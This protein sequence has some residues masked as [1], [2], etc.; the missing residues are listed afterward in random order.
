M[1]GRGFDDTL[2][3]RRPTIQTGQTQMRTGFIDEFQALDRVC[4][5]LAHKL[6]AQAFHA[7]RVALAVVER[8][9]FSAKFNAG[10]SRHIMLGCAVTCWVFASRS[11]NSAK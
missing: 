4:G 1:T 8:L 9:F 10:N 6:P 11:H 5:Y 2:A 3:R 7:R